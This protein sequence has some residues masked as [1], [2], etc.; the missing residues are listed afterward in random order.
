MKEDG[1]FKSINHGCLW[2]K[3]DPFILATQATKVFYLLDTMQQR[4]LTLKR[5]VRNM[6]RPKGSIA[7]AYVA[8][9]CLTI[10]SRYFDDDVETRHNRDGRNRERVAIARGDLSFFQHGADVLGAPS[11]TYLEHDYEKMVWSIL[12]NFPEVEPYIE[13]VRP[14]TIFIISCNLVISPN[15]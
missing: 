1:F 13:Y 5:F 12:N 10:C 2:Y 6:A 15:V 11:L 14:S 7:E 3:D 9:E 8:V 4:L